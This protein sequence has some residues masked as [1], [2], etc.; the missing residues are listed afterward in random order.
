MHLCFKPLQPGSPQLEE[1]KAPLLLL[2]SFKRAV[3]SRQQSD[4]IL[5]IARY[6][7]ETYVIASK[8]LQV[9]SQRIF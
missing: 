9:T 1:Q 6:Q 8:S 4:M 7:P 5:S 3:A 2:C